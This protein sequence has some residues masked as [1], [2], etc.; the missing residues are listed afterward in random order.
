VNLWRASNAWFLRRFSGLNGRLRRP[1]VP[2]RRG[3]N[4]LNCRGRL[5]RPHMWGGVCIGGGGKNRDVVKLRVA[6]IVGEMKAG[7]EKLLN[8]IIWGRLVPLLVFGNF[9][10]LSEPSPELG[11]IDCVYLLRQ[12][13]MYGSTQKWILSMENT[14]GLSLILESPVSDCKGR[15][16]TL[17]QTSD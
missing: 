9:R 7:L 12:A 15:S 1:H 17:C 16:L 2:R 6:L 8:L 13:E 5:K 10:M 11:L 14:I 4:L 3:G